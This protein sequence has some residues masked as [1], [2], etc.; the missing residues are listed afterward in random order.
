MAASQE[1]LDAINGTIV[2][3]DMKAITAD[4]L[5]NLLVMMAENSGNSGGTGDGALR[6]MI[7]IPETIESDGVFSREQMTGVP[8]FDE[9]IEEM[10]IHNAK[11]YEQILEKAENYESVMVV[12]DPS[13]FTAK[14]MNLMIEAMLGVS[15]ALHGVSVAE[16]VGTEA[17]IVDDENVAELGM[18]TTIIF[19]SYRYTNGTSSLAPYDSVQ[20]FA[21]GTLKFSTTLVEP[22]ESEE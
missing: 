7:P 8:E 17:L 14:Y 1:V 2:S 4:S 10:F 19:R 18:N 12:L 22:E 15:N 11:V 6:V 9:F 13:E 5:R 21:D 16:P 3:N 20:L